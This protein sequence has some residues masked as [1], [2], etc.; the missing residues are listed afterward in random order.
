V[1]F[2]KPVTTTLIYALDLT[3]HE[4]L[5]KAP[6]QLWFLTRKAVERG[7]LETFWKRSSA[8]QLENLARLLYSEE[9]VKRLRNDLKASTGIYFQM[10]DVAKSLYELI[11]NKV[12]IR[13]HL[14]TKK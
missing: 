4:D 9:I 11:A 8:L 6:A 1:N 12:E 7:E 13:P 5:K 10:D 3:N 2:A 14:R